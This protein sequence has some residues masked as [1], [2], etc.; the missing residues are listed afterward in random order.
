MSRGEDVHSQTTTLPLR[1][2]SRPGTGSNIPLASN[3]NPNIP[4]GNIDGP[5]ILGEFSQPIPRTRTLPSQH[6]AP[7]D[8]NNGS[9]LRRPTEPPRAAASVSTGRDSDDDVPLAVAIP[10]AL[11]AQKSIRSMDRKSSPRNPSPNPPR[12][13]VSRPSTSSRAAPASASRS[14]APSRPDTGSVSSSSAPAPDDLSR[15]LLEL[16][17]SINGASPSGVHRARTPFP[18]R[19]RDPGSQSHEMMVPN[20]G[21]PTSTPDIHSPMDNESIDSPMPRPPKPSAKPRPANLSD[22]HVPQS[23]VPSRSRRPSIT[24]ISS[25]PTNDT[26][27][28][29]NPP[30]RT[31][32][33]TLDSKGRRPIVPS[34]PSPLP[35]PPRESNS[36]TKDRPVSWINFFDL[37]AT[38]VN[39]L[40]GTSSLTPEESSRKTSNTPI[41]PTVARPAAQHSFPPENS[42]GPSTSSPHLDWRM[43]VKLSAATAAYQEEALAA[44]DVAQE[45]KIFVETQQKFCVVR[46]GVG[47]RARDVLEAVATK[48]MLHH[49][50][51]GDQRTGGW[52]LF[53]VVGDLGLERPLREYELVAEIF[54]TWDRHQSTNYFIVKRSNLRSVLSLKN[55]PSS[56]PINQGVVQWRSRKGK[57]SKRSL[58]L[59]EHSL[60]ISKKDSGK[61]EELLCSLGNFDAYTMSRDYRSPKPYV[62]ALRSTD[63]PRIFEDLN[64][65]VH[66]FSCEKGDGEHWVQTVMLA[67]SYV[68]RQERSVLFPGQSQILHPTRS[69]TL[70][71]TTNLHNSMP[72][73]HATP[74]GLGRSSTSVRSHTSTNSARLPSRKPTVPSAPLIDLNKNMFAEGSLL[75]MASL[76]SGPS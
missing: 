26:Q 70:H 58:R 12:L 23:S 48:G 39:L 19:S 35:L 29:G 46:I 44:A 17:I 75:A 69:H 2:R 33:R 76:A 36:G 68:L 57:W 73:T 47:M 5:E 63:S 4:P 56:P 72:P 34:P 21:L 27:G 32:S 14:R 18:T 1:L 61:D 62:F 67:R 74:R 28:S 66:I 53:E 65:S 16:Q 59:C 50:D 10:R 40:S 24:E 6:R 55:M 38:P 13:P 51:T 25:P 49:P 3:R 54:G 9:A 52:M 31:R 43:P 60:L 11:K 41:S 8:F 45:Q 42:D 71:P 22:K 7:S 15:R 20:A 37:G 30:L 64:D